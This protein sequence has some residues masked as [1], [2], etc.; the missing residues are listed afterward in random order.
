MKKQTITFEDSI[1]SIVEEWRKQQKKIPS[2]NE[3]VNIMLQRYGA[4]I[5]SETK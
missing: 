1:V 5:K 3:A 4:I 2:F